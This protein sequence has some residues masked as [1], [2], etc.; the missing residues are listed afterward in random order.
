ME[1]AVADSISSQMSAIASMLYYVLKFQNINNST[2]AAR[3]RTKSSCLNKG[4]KYD[5]NHNSG[6]QSILS[7]RHRR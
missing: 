4:E 7:Q 2:N 5:K 1:R 3:V 6:S